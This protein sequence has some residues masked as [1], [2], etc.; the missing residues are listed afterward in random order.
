MDSINLQFFPAGIFQDKTFNNCLIGGSYVNQGAASTGQ[1]IPAVTGKIIRIVSLVVNTDAAA[2]NFCR[3]VSNGNT[4]GSFQAPGNALP[5]LVFPFNPAGWA[6][7][8]EGFNI[9][10][11]TS[12]GS[13]VQC[14]A[15][16]I[17]FVL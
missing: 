2:S 10:V 11:T 7:S 5:S 6:D 4:I 16:F 12:A 9:T 15:R 1:L 14:F 8:A 17:S 3:L 13:G